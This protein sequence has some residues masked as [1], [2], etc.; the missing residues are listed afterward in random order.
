LVLKSAEADVLHVPLP[1]FSPDTARELVHKMHKLVNVAHPKINDDRSMRRLPVTGN[2]DDI[3]RTILATLWVSV[4]APIFR[5]LDLKKTTPLPRLWWCPTG[6][7]T[8]LPIHAAGIFNTKA[9]ESVYDFTISSYIPTLSTLLTPK[10]VTADHFKVLVVIQPSGPNPLPCT[11]DELDTIAGHMGTECLVKFGTTETPALVKD[12]LLNIPTASIVHLACHGQQNSK[13]LD[14]AL[15]LEDGQ[16]KVTQL[17]QLSVQ[18]A[19][20]VFLSACETAMGDTNLPDEVIHLAAALLFVGFCGAV[21]TMW[22]IR[23]SD[24]PKIADAFYGHLSSLS[25]SVSPD[26]PTTLNITHAAHALHVAV[27]KLREERNCSFR[28][29][30]PFIHLGF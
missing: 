26:S 23:D 10:P 16:L 8:S 25:M 18:K 27:T 30:V 20:L 11:R 1:Q 19:S 7:F 2:D 13:P 22:S 24:G 28:R 29:W 14:S 3:F 4:V 5:V 9:S 6:L 17:M 15:L 12:I 21:G